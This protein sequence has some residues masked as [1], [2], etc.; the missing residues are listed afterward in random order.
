M[1][2][3]AV[4]LHLHLKTPMLWPLIHYL[5]VKRI[6]VI[7]WTKGANLD[8]PDSKLRYELFN[9]IHRLSDALLLYSKNEIKYVK[10]QYRKKVFVANNT[11][12]FEDYPPLEQTKDEIRMELNIP[13]KKNVLFVGSMGIAGERKRVTH[14]INI[15]KTLDRSEVGLLIV[16][17]GMSEECSASVNPE[18][19]RVMGAVH[20]SKNLMISKLFKLADIYAVPGHVG[21]GI[22]QAFYWGLPVI[23][24]NC[25]QPPEIQYLISGRNGYIVP[26]HDIDALRSKIFYLLDNDEIRAEFS[27]NAREDILAKASIEGMFQSFYDAVESAVSQRKSTTLVGSIAI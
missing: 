27:R 9:Y 5:K 11:L 19:T 23:T 14:L 21:L 2:P 20:D 3:T 12:N 24:E 4:I 10:Q 6:P 25:N 1:R 8:R 18:N 26:D 7:L 15:F 22:N 17:S 13:F 16:G